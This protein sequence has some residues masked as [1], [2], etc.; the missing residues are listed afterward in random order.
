MKPS[1]LLRRDRFHVATA[2]FLEVALAGASDIERNRA[3]SVGLSHSPNFASI[4]QEG[5]NDICVDEDLHVVPVIGAQ[6]RVVRLHRQGNGRSGRAWKVGRTLTRRRG[7]SNPNQAASTPHFVTRGDLT[8]GVD[9]QPGILPVSD[10]S[11]I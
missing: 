5:A 6:V 9:R 1:P 2:L 4:V 7:Q 3:V 10:R 8:L 11:S